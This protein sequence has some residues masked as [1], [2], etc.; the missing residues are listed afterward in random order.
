LITLVVL[1]LLLAIAAVVQIR[2]GSGPR[3]E[4]SEDPA[5]RSPVP[6]ATSLSP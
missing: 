2:A 5:C 1:F 4:C 3:L 6:T